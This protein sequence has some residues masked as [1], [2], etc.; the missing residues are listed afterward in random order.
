MQVIFMRN[1]GIPFVRQYKPLYRLVLKYAHTV[2]KYS[3]ICQML[4]VV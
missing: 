2:D 1:K 3:L 4:Q